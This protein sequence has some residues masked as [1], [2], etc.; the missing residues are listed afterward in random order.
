MSTCPDEQ[1]RHPDLAVR[2]AQK[3]VELDGDQDYIYLD[4]LAAALANRSQFDKAQ[5]V[6]RR[7]IQLAPPENAGPLKHRLDLYRR[8]QPFRQT[9]DATPRRVA[10]T[11]GATNDEARNTQARRNDE[12][13]STN[14]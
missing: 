3:A 10:N 2:A 4:T 9:V 12:A 5:E 13:K 11:P 1:Y 7:A 14:R 8:G 6:M